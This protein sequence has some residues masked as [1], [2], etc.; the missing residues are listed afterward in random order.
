MLLCQELR[1]GKAAITDPDGIS[2]SEVARVQAQARL[3][4]A[5]LRRMREN[6][7]ALQNARQGLALTYSPATAAMY[8]RN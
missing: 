7:S 5:V 8:R 1:P 4:A 3:L 2:K 6:L